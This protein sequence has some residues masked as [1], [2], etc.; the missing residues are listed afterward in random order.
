VVSELYVDPAT[1]QARQWSKAY[2]G[3]AARTVVTSV[4]SALLVG[5]T[6]LVFSEVSF[7]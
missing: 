4:P 6:Y 1:L 5:N 3:G 7:L 2:Q